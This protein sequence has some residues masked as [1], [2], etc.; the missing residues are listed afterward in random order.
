MEELKGFLEDKG[1][2]VTTDPLKGRCLFTTKDFSPGEVIIPEEPYVCVPK[3]TFL[4]QVAIDV[5]DQAILWVF[6]MP[7]CLVLWK[8]LPGVKQGILFIPSK[9][10]WKM[11]LLECR[12][13]S[14][15]DKKWHM[16]V[17]PSIRLIVKI[18]LRRNL[19]NQKLGCN[20][21]T[22]CDGELNPLGK[23]LYPVI[24]IINHSCLPNAVLVFEGQLAVIRAV[25]PLPKGAEEVAHLEGMRCK[26]EKCNGFLRL[27]AEK[28]LRKKMF[29][30][31]SA[32][33]LQTRIALIKGLVKEGEWQ[34]ALEYC[35]M[36][37]SVFEKV[38]IQYTCGKLE[39]HHGNPQVAIDLLSKALDILQITHGTESPFT[40]DLLLKL[41]QARAGE[42]FKLTP[43]D[44]K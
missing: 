35:R 21:L 5:S 22:I 31:T 19:Q 32:Y 26:D 17:T 1:L 33:L 9:L 10:G 7:G 42:S 18:F 37:I 13:L 6:G 23:G 29:V 38:Y 40:K 24:A 34:K 8:H 4:I 12:A 36:T 39:W 28:I 44:I 2:S 20:A 41:E 30:S 14:R 15:L 43:N 11:H 25:Q 27:K 3:S 16:F